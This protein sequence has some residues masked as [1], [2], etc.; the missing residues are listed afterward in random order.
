MAFVNPNK[1]A[2]LAPVQTLI[3][4]DWTQKANWYCI[5]S[6]DST[7]NY[8]VGDLVS[9]AAAAGGDSNGTPYITQ[10]AAG[11]TAVGVIAAVGLAQSVAGILPYGGPPINP[12]NLAQVYAPIAKAGQNYYAL[13]IDDPYVIFE[14][15]EGGT[16][17]NLTAAS[18]GLNA[19]IAIGANATATTP[20]GFL[21]N[22]YLNG[23][24]APT[25]TVTY[26]LKII[27]FAP[28][29]DNHFVTIPATGGGYQKWWVMIN[30]HQYRAG[31]V[32][33]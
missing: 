7:Y 13:V 6:T 30:N 21:S 33:P 19:N 9:L 20:T 8:M 27:R 4:A 31:I 23:N 18:V 2:G 28:R 1:P 32:A 25:T 5:P 22:T 14:I 24:T 11:G 29:L 10:C 12:N 16:A 15:Q 26:N 17:T 3:G